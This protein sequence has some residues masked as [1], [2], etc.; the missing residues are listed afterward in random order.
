MVRYLTRIGCL[1]S[2][3]SPS[4]QA[5][6]ADPDARASEQMMSLARDDVVMII[7]IIS[8]RRVKMTSLLHDFLLNNLYVLFLGYDRSSLEPFRNYG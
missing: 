4:G 1:Q 7:A 6:H 2:L 8:T 5:N 3:Q